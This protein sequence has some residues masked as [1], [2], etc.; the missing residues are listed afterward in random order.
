MVEVVPG[1]FWNQIKDSHPFEIMDYLVKMP[2]WAY[3]QNKSTDVAANEWKVME[4][5]YDS[6]VGGKLKNDKDND[7]VFFA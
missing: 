2:L 3:L 5:D 6:R 4:M 1:K 7:S